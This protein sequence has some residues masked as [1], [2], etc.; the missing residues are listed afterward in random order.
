MASIGLF[1]GKYRA[2]RW[3]VSGCLVAS[4]GLFGG[5]Y[6]AVWWQVAAERGL[7]SEISKQLPNDLLKANSRDKQY[8]DVR[9][10][11]AFLGARNL[12]GDYRETTD[13]PV[14]GPHT[15]P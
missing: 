9:K 12:L 7:H 15:S 3:Q 13:E 10:Y 5:K 1:S 4:I 14:L 11:F 2:V 8:G 6:R